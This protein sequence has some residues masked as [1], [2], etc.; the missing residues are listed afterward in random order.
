ML[1]KF[2]KDFILDL[3]DFLHILGGFEKFPFVCEFKACE[4]NVELV[5]D[6]VDLHDVI[7]FF[8]EFLDLHTDFRDVLFGVGK[9]VDGLGH[10]VD[11]VGNFT[12]FGLEFV[13]LVFSFLLDQLDFFF[14]NLLEFAGIEVS[15]VL[16]VDLEHAY[17][18]TLRD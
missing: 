5:K 12:K 6:T 7:D 9:L 16:A 10:S 3:N 15:D 18:D 11:L 4:L 1:L 17:R 2:V 13:G 14:D 8:L